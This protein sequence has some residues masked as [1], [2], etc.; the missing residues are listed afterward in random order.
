MTIKTHGRMMTD[1]TVGISQ[2]ALVD[3][4]ANQAIVTDGQ[5]VLRFATVGAGGCVGA[6][7]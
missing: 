6:Q 4:T 3:G 2:L 1:N 5:G 7:V